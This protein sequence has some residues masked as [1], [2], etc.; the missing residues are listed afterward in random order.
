MSGRLVSRVALVTGASRGIGAGIAEGF[1]REDADL[2]LA[3]TSEE[4]LK[5]VAGRS[6]SHGGRVETAAVDVSDRDACFHLVDQAVA[7]FGRLDVLVNNA[8]I[9]L[10]RGF[11]DYS[12]EEF[13]RIQ[14]VNLHGVFHLTQAALPH[15]IANRYGKIINVASTAGKWASRN[16]SAYNVAKHGVVGMTRCVALEMAAHG[17]GVNAICPGLVDTDLL[18]GFLDAHAELDGSDRAAVREG[19]LT[20]VPQGHFLDVS[21]CANLAIYLASGES[22]GMTGQS[23]L[24]DG[25]M[26]VV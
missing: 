15:M 18:D 20:R 26:L 17:I 19:L 7:A 22:D 6:A 1:A 21:D 2:L 24:L 23:L 9:Y 14:Q 25:G 3:A 8:G 12:Y 4:S 5:E 16:Q 11:L 13:E 10:A